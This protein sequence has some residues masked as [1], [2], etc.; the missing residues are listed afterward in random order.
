MELS[1]P[2]LARC[3]SCNSQSPKSSPPSSEA[4]R[5]EHSGRECEEE[6]TSPALL[7]HQMN[8]ADSIAKALIE[9][10]P[11]PTVSIRPS[12]PSDR[13]KTAIG[14]SRKP[15]RTSSSSFL[16]Q[17]RA[18]VVVRRRISPCFCGRFGNGSLDHLALPL[19]MSIAAVISQVRAS[20]LGFFFSFSINEVSLMNVVGVFF[21]ED[22]IWLIGNSGIGVSVDCYKIVQL[23]SCLVCY[24]QH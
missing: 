17:R 18:R 8:G 11:D 6:V 3:S 1:F 19:G 24:L 4:S 16:R 12:H 9:A 15:Q 5:C 2:P 14:K 10:G 23:F 21:L 7:P 22:L 20:F 13:G